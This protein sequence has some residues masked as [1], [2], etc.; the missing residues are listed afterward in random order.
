MRDRGAIR[1]LV[2]GLLSL[3]FGLLAPFA[4]WSG[5]R[6]LRRIRASGGTL[7]G[8]GMAVF[9]VLAGVTGALFTV[10]GIALW[11]LLSS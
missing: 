7:H 8:T 1:T 10:G 5:T 3:L 4:I 11:L 6:C 2:L 9:G